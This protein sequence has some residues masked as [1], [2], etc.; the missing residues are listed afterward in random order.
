MQD[1]LATINHVFREVFGDD[2]LEVNHQTTARDI[3]AWDSLMHVNLV[4]GVER[5]FGVR[6]SSS[7]VA[8]LQTVGELVQLVDRMRAAQ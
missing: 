6:F 4:L 5:E 8:T 1:T 3:Q 2:S 7:Q